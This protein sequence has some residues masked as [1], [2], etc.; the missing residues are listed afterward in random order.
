MPTKRASSDVLVKLVS[1]AMRIPTVGGAEDKSGR[2]DLSQ[3][4]RNIE[5][6]EITMMP[7]DHEPRLFS[8]RLIR[9]KAGK[10]FEFMPM[11]GAG[12][13]AAESDYGRKLRADFFVKHLIGNHE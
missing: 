6:I 10:T 5:A 1:E 11:I 2:G 13:G 3:L 12:H 4:I 7:G 9:M 8:I